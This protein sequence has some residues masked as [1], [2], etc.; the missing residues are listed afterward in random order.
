MRTR[1]KLVQGCVVL[2]LLSATLLSATLL[3]AQSALELY[4]R[5]LVQEQSYGNLR[6][7]IGLY[8]RAAQAADRDRALA[9]KA[10]FREAESYR[11]LGD[12]K[13]AEL[14][15]TVMRSYPEQRQPVAAAEAALAALP[16]PGVRQGAIGLSTRL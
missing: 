11:R 9:A 13:A 4:Q 2:T 8:E 15:T 7:A 10:L 14:Y 1:R 6:E 16:R 12:P 5:G 3:W